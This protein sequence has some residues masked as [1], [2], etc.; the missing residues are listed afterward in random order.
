MTV[1]LFFLV[2]FLAM[3]AL[4]LVGGL[5]EGVGQRS[6][7]RHPLRRPATPR[8]EATKLLVNGSERAAW[9]LL[10]ELPLG[11]HAVCPKVRLEDFLTPKGAEWY[12]LRGH[13]SSRHIDFLVDE[14]WRPMLAIEVDGSSHDKPGREYADAVKDAAL[15]AAEVPLLRLRVGE[16]W[17]PRLLPGPAHPNG[18]PTSASRTRRPPPPRSPTITVRPA[19]HSSRHVSVR[20]GYTSTV[21]TASA[22]NSAA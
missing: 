3:A 9:Q 16:D 21:V 14:D 1:F 5:L 12:R 22:S 2:F 18:S 13:I 19:S 10:Q 8:Y 6:R 4:A 11:A 20:G 15:A 17:R 7:Y